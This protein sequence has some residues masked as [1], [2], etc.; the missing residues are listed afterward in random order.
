MLVRRVARKILFVGGVARRVACFLRL[1]G[2]SSLR[3]IKVHVESI[4]WESACAVL[5][6]G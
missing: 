5:T 6:G 2:S 1:L 3:E 4:L